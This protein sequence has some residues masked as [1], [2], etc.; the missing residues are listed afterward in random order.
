MD[1]FTTTKAETMPVEN[2]DE[3][4]PFW[5]SLMQLLRLLKYC[6]VSVLISVVAQIL[7]QT[8]GQ[9][10]N[11]LGG[12]IIDALARRDETDFLWQTVY[13]TLSYVAYSSLMVLEFYIKTRNRTQLD[14][15]L[16][17]KLYSTLVLDKPQS[18]FD[19]SLSSDLGMRISSDAG[20]LASD[21]APWVPMMASQIM[22]I[23]FGVGFL[24]MIHVKL[25]LATAIAVPFMALATW[26]QSKWEQPLN[27]THKELL[28]D[29][30]ARAVETLAQIKTVSIFGQQRQ[31][32]RAFAKLLAAVDIISTKLAVA[33]SISNSAVSLAF[34]FSIAF[35]F[36]YGGHLVLNGEISPGQFLAFSMFSLNI[37]ATVNYIPELVT[38]LTSMRSTATR[39]FKVLEEAEKSKRKETEKLSATA[40]KITPPDSFN[41][42]GHI[43]FEKV[44]FSYPTRP[45][46]PVLKEFDLEILP[47]QS[48]ALVGSSGGG[49]STIVALLM[50]F[51]DGYTGKITIDGY[52]LAEL[53]PA[54]LRRQIG[55]VSQ[56]PVL[57]STTIRENICYGVWEEEAD[58]ELLDESDPV[59]LMK[60]AF[61]DLKKEK[62]SE[63]SSNGGDSSHGN[64]NSNNTSKKSKISRKNL[65]EVS[66]ER[67]EEVAKMANAHDFIMALPQGYDT[68][69]GE[70]G[71]LLSGGQKQRIAIARAL[72]RNPK[73]LITDEATSA[74]DN[75]SERIVQQALDRLMEDRTCIVI[76]HRLSTIRNCAPIC[77]INGGKVLE[78]GTH[79]ELMELD[80][81][82]Y[83]KL[84]TYE[85]QS[86][87]LSEVKEQILQDELRSSRSDSLPVPS[88]TH[89]ENPLESQHSARE[90]T[91]GI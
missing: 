3:N 17:L 41:V 84:H 88:T 35:S 1:E 58:E 24:L 86:K 43:K 29:T 30:N 68:L 20:Q 4:V 13:L 60:R 67:I 65:V 85:E 64:K 19:Q 8:S 53:S 5:P 52:D 32:V 80:G 37:I 45:D 50:Q 23:V 39:I 10:E 26:I 18:F 9:L 33:H 82:H 76:A 81:G 57:F 66:Q 63:A 25:T 56:E 55:L 47:G 72:L 54:W 34:N 70:R 44:T 48:T 38:E 49:K 83:R 7:R 42:E 15:A 36:W 90:R 69:V 79:N 21:L 89:H 31:E 87:H 75:D 74:L 62:E 22:E 40:P 28:S 14:Q 12:T 6:W 61:G 16:K 71:S 77:Y 91:I 59:A 78:S 2:E 51:Y 73:I 11:V 27:D 46:Q